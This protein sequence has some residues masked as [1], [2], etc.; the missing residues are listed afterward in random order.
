MRSFSTRVQRAASPTVPRMST[1]LLPSR[2]ISR[3]VSGGTP[4]RTR[5][6]AEDR[7]GELDVQRRRVPRQARKRPLP[8]GEMVMI[9]DG[10]SC[11]AGATYDGR[12]RLGGR[13]AEA[14][15]GTA[16][17]ER[18]VK[19]AGDCRLAVAQGGALAGP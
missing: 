18:C 11:C 12:R 3:G 6:R 14:G 1:A 8:A 13:V 7:N 5:I 10:C 4:S 17:F 2:V 19:G 16:V 15:D 9:I